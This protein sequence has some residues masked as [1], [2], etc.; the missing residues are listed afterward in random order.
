MSYSNQLLVRVPDRKAA[1]WGDNARRNDERRVTNDEC[2]NAGTGSARGRQ[3]MCDVR[4]ESGFSIPHSSLVTPHW[5]V[6]A[7]KSR[8]GAPSGDWSHCHTACGC[9]AASRSGVAAKTEGADASRANITSSRA[10]HSPRRCRVWKKSAAC[11]RII[12]VKTQES[13]AQYSNSLAEQ[14]RL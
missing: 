14:R 13:V 8:V 3:V 5:I 12:K 1:S 6:R 10:F 11:R 9:E 2:E 7:S 4:C